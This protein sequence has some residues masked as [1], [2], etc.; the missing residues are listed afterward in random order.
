[1]VHWEM[2]RLQEMPTISVRNTKPPWFIWLKSCNYILGGDDFRKALLT[3]NFCIQA[4]EE[5]SKSES[6]SFTPPTGKLT[7]SQS[8]VAA[9]FD[10]KRMEP[11]RKLIDILQRHVRVQYELNFGDILNA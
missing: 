2:R 3:A 11:M 5:L 9:D 8:T 4:L 7:N 10:A 6:S 1:M